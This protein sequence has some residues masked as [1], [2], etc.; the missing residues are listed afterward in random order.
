MI[1]EFVRILSQIKM[2]KFITTIQECDDSENLFIQ[3]PEQILKQLNWK[4]GTTITWQIQD[5]AILISK[6]K[7]INNQYE[8]KEEE[9]KQ[10]T[11]NL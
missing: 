10:Y 1:D 5:D 2:N 11:D 8:T 9:I 6:Y 3:I 4:E 7:G